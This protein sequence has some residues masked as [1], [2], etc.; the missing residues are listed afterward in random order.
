[1]NTSRELWQQIDPL[2]TAALE[3][4]EDAR[5]AWLQDLDQTHPQLTP[6]LRKMLATHDRAERSREL[7]TGPRI[8][9]APPSP[10]NF[11]CGARIGPF[12]L[13][14]LLGGGG[15]GEVWL[16]KQ[17]DGRVEREVAVKL[18]TVYLHSDV[19]RERIRRERDILA[20]LTHPNI[21]R[22]LDAGASDDEG[23][24][25][26]PY[27]AME[28]VE[29]EALTRFVSTRQSTIAERLNLFRQIL[30]AVA[31]AHRHLVVHRDLKPA[32]ILIDQTGQ[33]K[34]LDFGIAKLLDDE[35]AAVDGN[36]LDLTRMSG[37]VMTLRYAAPEQVAAGTITT[38]TDVY[39]LGVILH[40]LVTEVSPYRATREG[41][42]LTESMLARDETAVPSA[43]AP[44]TV[45]RQVKG[46]LD[47]IILKAMRRDPAARYA[48]VEQF[49]DDIARYL[50]RRPVSAR[51]GTWRY[52]AGRFALRHKLPLA[53]AAA[54]IVTMAAGL[55]L[56]DRQRRVAVA[57]K[58]RAEKHFASVRKLANSFMFDVH[59]EIENLPSS[60][61]AREMLV[62]TSLEYLDSLQG[63]AGNDPAL[64]YE[65]AAAYRKIGEIQGQPGG[66]NTGD[67][68]AAIG[69]FEKGKR[70]FIALDALRPNDIMAM[71][72]QGSLR[73]SLARAYFL[74]GDSRWEAET[75]AALVLAERVAAMPGATP[76]DRAR[77]A[78]TRSEQA[79]LTKLLRGPSPELEAVIRK[80]IATLEALAHETP[81]D[82]TVRKYLISA[83]E[84]AAKT[85][86][87]S[88]RPATVVEGIGYYRKALALIREVITANPNDAKM[89]ESEQ[90][91]IA[92]L[93]NALLL[94]GQLREADR[95][96]A[97][98]VE[99]GAKLVA[100]D[101]KNIAP[102][103]GYISALGIAALI[104]YREGDHPRA[105]RFGR[106]ELAATARIPEDSRNTR[107]MRGSVAEAKALIGAALLASASRAAPDRVK[108]LAMLTEARSLLADAMAFVDQVRA[109]KED[110]QFQ[111][112]ADEV[113]AAALKACDE[114]LAKLGK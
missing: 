67:L 74:K 104:A 21:A 26:Q 31:H 79:F 95:I 2:L 8:A 34:L 71:R 97:E 69:N 94:S 62:K 22:L 75:A 1:M 108:Q 52:L 20:K 102:A 90:S 32:N 40:E 50:E 58:A 30:A 56:V 11:A 61:K 14:R 57:E 91:Y 107:D 38:A 54:V 29:G 88:D 70:L 83:Y 87:L 85:L 39:A 16:A 98:A 48:S 55:V 42:P 12:V 82:V 105:I 113:I 45:A 81:G 10:S 72:E 4:E 76:G 35:G 46:D 47:A 64:L 78:S 60:L 15:M 73:Y 43:L 89:A 86:S 37:R 77:A 110:S 25:G 7:E 100:R 5:A 19:W 13:D 68:S 36:A 41:T 84:H 80:S 99:L 93:A 109:A 33:V 59:G 92:Q 6:M 27:L 101:P 103:I 49:D 18:P 3:L 106:E 44:A 112:G 9:L 66:A 111:P 63:E 24:R 114:E 53:T 65:L 23:S 51:V 17:A 96:I 28:Y